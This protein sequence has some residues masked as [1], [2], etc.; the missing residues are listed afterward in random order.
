MA[1]FYREMQITSQ[2]NHSHLVRSYDAGPVVATHFL[3][4][5]FIEGMDLEQLVRQRGPLPVATACDYIRQAALGLQH[6]HEHGLVHRDI[7]PS[8]LLVTN[9]QGAQ[10]PGMVKILDLGLARSQE[11]AHG[12]ANTRLPDGMSVTT[13]TLDGAGLLGTVDYMSPQQALDFQRVDIRADIY[14]LGCTL[15][16]PAICR[17]IARASRVM[18]VPSLPNSRSSAIFRRSN[19][20]KLVPGRLAILAARIR[21]PSVCDSRA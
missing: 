6:I 8:N 4:M 5:E 2:L 1:R 3:A 21:P 7:K 20:G 19:P 17:Q 15:R 11:G 12:K 16:Q 18:H 10:S 9:D 13:W 14:S